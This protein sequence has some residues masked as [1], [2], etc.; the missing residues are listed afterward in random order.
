MKK[1]LAILL[2]LVGVACASRPHQE[3]LGS[4]QAALCYDFPQ[5]G[6]CLSPTSPC[7]PSEAMLAGRCVVAFGVELSTPVVCTAAPVGCESLSAKTGIA[8]SCP[9]TDPLEVWCCPASPCVQEPPPPPGDLVCDPG[10]AYPASCGRSSDCDD[11][12]ACTYD[13]CKGGTCHLDWHPNGEPCGAAGQFCHDGACCAEVAAPVCV[14][15]IPQVECDSDQDCDDGSLCTIDECVF[16]GDGICV[17]TLT[18]DGLCGPGGRCIGAVC[19]T[20]EGGQ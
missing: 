9:G 18:D 16:G 5:G 2:A 4:T 3:P 20:T 13:T 15:P 8:T 11:G 7:S 14:E 10:I 6:T 19:C 1:T 12:N 17:Y